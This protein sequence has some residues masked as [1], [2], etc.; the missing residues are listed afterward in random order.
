MI[1]YDKTL[2]FLV[3][4][5]YGHFEGHEGIPMFIA[6]DGTGFACMAGQGIMISQCTGT[7]AVYHR[8]YDDACFYERPPLS[9]LTTEIVNDNVTLISSKRQVRRLLEP[10][11][12]KQVKLLIALFL[13]SGLS[14]GVAIVIWII[15]RAFCW[16]TISVSLLSALLCALTSRFVN[17]ID[18][19]VV[20]DARGKVFK[21]GDERR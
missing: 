13:L 16:Q 11:I 12:I 21:F 2:A 18:N 6:D 17:D 7:Y 14:I 1:K 15:F 19:T 20:K 8:L 9:V 3:E 5:H 4:Y 10:Y